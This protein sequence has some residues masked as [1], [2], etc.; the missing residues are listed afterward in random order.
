MTER[1]DF[2]TVSEEKV[3]ILERYG[4]QDMQD[5]CAE[6]RRAWDAE[7]DWQRR[8]EDS[9]VE[10]WAGVGWRESYTN[11]L[12]TLRVVISDEFEI[13]EGESI[14]EVIARVLR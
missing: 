8:W 12:T 9:L 1:L 13:D 6:I 14:P 7:N 10:Q 4:S 5:L 2:R 3:G 11:S